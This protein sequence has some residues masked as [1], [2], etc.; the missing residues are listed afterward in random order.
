M[1]ENVALPD[2]IIEFVAPRGV[3]DYWSK[4]FLLIMIIGLMNFIRDNIE[5]GADADT[6][7]AN[8]IEAAPIG[9]PFCLLALSL[10]GRLKRMQDELIALAATD[11][12][13]GLNNRRAFYERV[14]AIPD[15]AKGV[16]MII[17]ADHFKRVNDTY[18]HGIGDLCL[19][20]I[21]KHLIAS[22]R[23]NDIVAR[24][25]GEEFA[26]VMIGV[27]RDMAECIGARLVKGVMLAVAHDNTITVTL[28]VG[29]VMLAHLK[30]FDTYMGLADEALYIAKSSG[31]ARIVLAA[32]RVPTAAVKVA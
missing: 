12:L 18:G 16:L 22:V 28:S 27:D 19:Q 29:A 26:V 24:I 4:V 1:K 6:I 25:G 11:M 14:A 23:E 13:T 9:L 32:D 10:I 15:A 31:R 3:V 20:Q 2:R 7:Y 8:V 17:D 5:H 30:Q 21:A